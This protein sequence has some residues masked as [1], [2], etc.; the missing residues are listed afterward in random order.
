MGY[1]NSLNINTEAI[2]FWTWRR[3][4]W[5]GIKFQPSDVSSKGMLSD[6][7]P[8][9]WWLCMVCLVFSGQTESDIIFFA[10]RSTGDLSKLSFLGCV[11][12]SCW[13]CHLFWWKSASLVFHAGV[14]M[15]YGHSEIKWSLWIPPLF[16]T[17]DI[18]LT[19]VGVKFSACSFFLPTFRDWCSCIPWGILN[20]SLKAWSCVRLHCRFGK[21]LGP[22]SLNL[23]W[24][25]ADLQLPGSMMDV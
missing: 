10:H 14:R 13:E 3:H 16:W 17:S 25:I 11:F 5:L 9:H 20:L 18:R 24:G 2:F 19:E 15:T 12:P 1:L 23:S 8:V 4:P 22:W 6:K 21:L 7:F